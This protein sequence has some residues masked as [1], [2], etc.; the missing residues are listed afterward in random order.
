MQYANICQNAATLGWRR[1]LKRI[2]IR[3]HKKPVVGF[4]EEFSQRCTQLHGSAR[5]VD[6]FALT[7]QNLKGPD[8]KKWVGPGKD[9]DNGL[10][11]V[12]CFFF[13]WTHWGKNMFFKNRWVAVLLD[14]PTSHSVWFRHHGQFWHKNWCRKVGTLE[15]H[16]AQGGETSPPPVGV[17]RGGGLVSKLPSTSPGLGWSPTAE[18]VS[19]RGGSHLVMVDPEMG[20]TPFFKAGKSIGLADFQHFFRILCSIYY[21]KSTQEVA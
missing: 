10:L 4:L 11:L 16:G 13:P 17:R 20:G 21:G 12:S 19:S 9:G 18:V 14:I 7:Q 8:G 1:C 15:I 5:A 3:T 2:Q 6:L